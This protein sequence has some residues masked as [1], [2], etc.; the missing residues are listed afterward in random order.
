[1]EVGPEHPLSAEVGRAPVEP[2]SYLKRESGQIRVRGGAGG[3]I[4]SSSPVAT[5]QATR[6]SE[7]EAAPGLPIT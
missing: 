5:A 4:P 3:F 7:V 1:M 2:G 6:R